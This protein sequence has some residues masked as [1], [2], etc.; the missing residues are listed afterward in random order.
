[1]TS[2]KASRKTTSPRTP[3]VQPPSNHST[4]ITWSAVAVVLLFVVALV[5]VKLTGATTATPNHSLSTAPLTASEVRQIAAT[6][7]TPT[8][9]PPAQVAAPKATPPSTGLLTAAS[10]TGRQLPEVFY[11]GAEYCPYCAAERWALTTALSRFGSFTG[12]ASMYSSPTDYAP[13]TPTVTYTH[14]VYSSKYLTFSAVEAYS[15]VPAPANVPPYQALQSLSPAQAK[16]VSTYDPQRSFPFVDVANRYTQVGAAFDPLLLASLTTSQVAG[17]LNSQLP[18]AQSIRAAANYLTAELC[19][20]TNGQP[21]SVCRNPAI[22]A[23]AK[24]LGIK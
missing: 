21:G 9:T 16:L 4:L 17:D 3:T 19:V 7:I 13:S 20:V 14:A 6:S 1:M 10:S 23:D 11:F 12:L 24:T 8:P 18:G 5:V 22:V 2:R 15:N